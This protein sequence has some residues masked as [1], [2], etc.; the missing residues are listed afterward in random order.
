MFMYYCGQKGSKFGESKKHVEN[1]KRAGHVF[2]M[3]RVTTF[4]VTEFSGF[5]F[6]TQYH[7]WLQLRADLMRSF[8]YLYNNDLVICKDSPAY[9]TI[10]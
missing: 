7:A 4:S 10:M 6:V 8:G 1:K 3:C 2:D 5:F 9:L